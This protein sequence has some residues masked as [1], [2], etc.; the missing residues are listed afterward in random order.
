MLVSMGRPFIAET[1]FSHPSK[2]DL[3]DAAHDHG[4]RVVLHAVMVPEE[5]AVE[6]VARR[7]SSGGHSVPEEKIRARYRRVWPLVN[8]AIGRC[9]QAYVYDNSGRTL[10]QVAR[11]VSGMATG[12][13][14]WPQWSPLPGEE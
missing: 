4:F 3:I 9:D 6:R 1:V 12:D 11:F 13:V 8:R 7:V 10:R 14:H 2:L 5:L